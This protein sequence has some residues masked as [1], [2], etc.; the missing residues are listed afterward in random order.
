MN[1]IENNANI[2]EIYI[3]YLQCIIFIDQIKIIQKYIRMK[4]FMKNIRKYIHKHKTK[5]LMNDIIEFSYLPPQKDCILL[6][7]GGFNYRIH[8]QSFYTAYNLL[9]N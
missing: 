4:L 3:S 7:N 2:V 9:L 5:N 8:E 6:K 1:V